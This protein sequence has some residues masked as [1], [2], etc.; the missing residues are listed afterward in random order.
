MG[1]R[2]MQLLAAEFG[3]WEVGWTSDEGGAV[4]RPGRCC[5]VGRVV[6][7]SYLERRGERQG[8]QL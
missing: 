7:M 4:V 3:R 2:S 1:N 5:G 6:M 8:R